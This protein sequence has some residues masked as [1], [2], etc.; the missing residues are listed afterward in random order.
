M[1]AG[2]TLASATSLAHDIHA[3]V[4]GRGGASEKARSSSHGARRC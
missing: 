3:T 4:I 2:F 1:V